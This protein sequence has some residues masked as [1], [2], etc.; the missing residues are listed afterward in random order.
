MTTKQY[1]QWSKLQRMMKSRA[2][3]AVSSRKHS[4]NVLG[5]NLISVI[6]SRK[7]KIWTEVLTSKLYLFH[8]ESK[9]GEAKHSVQMIQYSFPKSRER[10]NQHRRLGQGKL[11]K[12][13]NKTIYLK[14]AV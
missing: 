8:V 2:R 3:Y 1:S 13:Y 4:S 12:H 9:C 14:K 5:C 10:L 7:Y 6:S 11:E